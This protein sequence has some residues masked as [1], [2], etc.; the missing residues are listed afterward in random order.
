MAAG[1][2]QASS[3]G[4]RERMTE[5]GRAVWECFYSLTCD[6]PSILLQSFSDTLNL[7]GS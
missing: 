1:R 5:G 6:L 2:A 4:V 7:C 3:G